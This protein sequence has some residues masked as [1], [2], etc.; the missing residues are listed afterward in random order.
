M[1]A[2]V[3]VCACIRFVIYVSHSPSMLLCPAFFCPYLLPVTSQLRGVCT[4]VCGNVQGH[5]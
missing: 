1:C 3:C 2:C 5:K 4:A